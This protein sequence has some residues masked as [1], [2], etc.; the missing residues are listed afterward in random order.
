VRARNV[1]WLRQWEATLPPGSAAETG[2]FGAMVRGV[3]RQARRG[4]GMPFVTTLDNRLVGQ[5]TVTGI[6][7]GS[8]RW[9]Q[10]GYWIDREHA[11]QGVTPLAV[12]LVVDHCFEAVGLH[13]IEIAIRPENTASLR[14]VEKLGLRREAQAPRYLH[15]NGD[16]RDHEIFAVTAEEV[17][18]GLLSRYLSPR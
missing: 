13:R 6:T 7:W 18:E 1:D 5:V 14:V 15:I 9:A 4:G 3:R 16:W 12:A 11:G 10:V 8:A 17:P 2:S